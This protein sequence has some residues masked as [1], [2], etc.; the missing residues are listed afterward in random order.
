MGCTLGGVNWHRSI[1]DKWSFTELFCPRFCVQFNTVN[2]DNQ[3]DLQETSTYWHRKIKL[4]VVFLFSILFIVVKY[5]SMLLS[6]LVKYIK[7]ELTEKKNLFIMLRKSA[8][9]QQFIYYISRK[10]SG[11]SVMQEDK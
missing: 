4:S 9:S 8:Y 10:E 3:G 1:K 6:A 11:I 7:A 2:V 5:L